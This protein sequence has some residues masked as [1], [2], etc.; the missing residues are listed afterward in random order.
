MITVH[1]LKGVQIKWLSVNIAKQ[2]YN[3]L[4]CSICFAFF[5]QSDNLFSYLLC[6]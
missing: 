4:D 5:N 6:T 2:K 1:T 3:N